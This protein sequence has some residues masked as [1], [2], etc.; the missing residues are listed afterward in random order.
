MAKKRRGAEEDARNTQDDTPGVGKDSPI[1]SSILPGFRDW[2]TRWSGF[3][4]EYAT[5][6]ERV[7]LREPVYRLPGMILDE[8]ASSRGSDGRTGRPHPPL[9]P[10]EDAMAEREFVRVCRSFSTDTIG[11]WE[12]RPINYRLL[13]EVDRAETQK[14][15]LLKDVKNSYE[16]L[17]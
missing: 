5:W 11:V 2:A 13:E 16:Q 1:S 4:N 14:A 3:R 15:G 17:G 6:W 7:D 8:L 12:E 10:T 9:I